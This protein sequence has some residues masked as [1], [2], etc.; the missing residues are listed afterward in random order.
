[1]VC[2]EQ[3]PKQGSGMP[4]RKSGGSSPRLPYVPRTCSASTCR[5]VPVNFGVP[6]CTNGCNSLHE[7]ALVEGVRSRAARANVSVGGAA[8]VERQRGGGVDSI[9]V[10]FRDRSDDDDRSIYR[11]LSWKELAQYRELALGSPLQHHQQIRMSTAGFFP[12]EGPASTTGEKSVPRGFL[13]TASPEHWPRPV[14]GRM[15]AGQRLLSR[16]AVSSPCSFSPPTSMV[17][18]NSRGIYRD[19][20][21]GN[22]HIGARGGCG[23][24]FSDGALTSRRGDFDSRAA[25]L[26]QRQRPPSPFLL[27][28]GC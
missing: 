23:C 25:T 10:S 16:P 13:G 2:Q 5:R 6:L 1:M 4:S 22:A 27:E 11:R 8:T 24:V 9:T 3:T 19:R 15:T 20:G 14:V 18:Y 7:P 12:A 21:S 17:I 28:G 26:A